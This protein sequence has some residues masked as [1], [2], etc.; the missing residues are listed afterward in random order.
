MTVLIH[1]S[2]N[3][4]QECPFLYSLTSTYISK[5]IKDLNLRPETLNTNRRKHEENTGH[6]NGQ[7][8]FG[9]EY[10]STGNKSRNGQMGLHK[11][12]KEQ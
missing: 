6:S 7:G 4:V 1:N 8:N 11:T 9:E 12:E 10:K 5:W 3:I 2:T